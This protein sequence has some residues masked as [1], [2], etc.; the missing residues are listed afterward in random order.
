[1][2]IPEGRAG[3][4]TSTMEKKY[5]IKIAGGQNQFKGKIVRLGHLGHYYPDDMKTMIT[6]FESTLVDLGLI[7]SSGPGIEALEKST[8]ETFE[9]TST[10][11]DSEL[12]GINT[13]YDAV[14]QLMDG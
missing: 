7:A 10:A 6:A 3:E 5:G 14:S 2:M 4:V 12:S 9:T 8:E 13:A 1:V 11:V